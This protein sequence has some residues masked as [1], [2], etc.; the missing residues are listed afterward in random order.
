MLLVRDLETWE[1][2]GEPLDALV[3]RDTYPDGEVKAAVV[4]CFGNT[5]T[6]PGKLLGHWGGRWSIEE[7]FMKADR[8]DKLGR[9]FP[10]REGFA[11]AWVHFAFLLY[12][13]LWLFDHYQPEVPLPEPETG[14][15]L[16]IR[17]PHYALISLGRILQIVF[18]HTEAWKAKRR[19]VLSRLGVSELP[20]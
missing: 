15:L 1:S 20:P 4:A 17:G 16:V 9:L 10:C 12:T 14:G 3:I 2:A 18:D 19:H 7:F 8:Y 13:L 11:R 6:D 5:E